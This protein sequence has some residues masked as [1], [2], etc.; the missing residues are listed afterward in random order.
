MKP[1]SQDLR[2]NAICTALAVA[3]G[4][5]IGWLDLHTTEVTVTVVA[6]LLAGLLLGILQPKAAWRWAV[7]LALGLPA[8]AMAGRLL[9]VRTAEPIRSDPRVALVALAFA[10]VGCYGGVAARRI[11]ARRTPLG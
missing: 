9:G 4:L 1:G 7:L 5:G 10:L 8:M 3:I 6:L 2:R 11:V